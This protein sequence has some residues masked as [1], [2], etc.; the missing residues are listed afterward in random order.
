MV[1]ELK[2]E[3]ELFEQ[4]ILRYQLLSPEERKRRSR[5]SLIR[6]GVLNKDGTQK[7][8]IITESHLH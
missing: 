1:A 6:S 4:H 3:L 2:K 5:E 7:T 8:A